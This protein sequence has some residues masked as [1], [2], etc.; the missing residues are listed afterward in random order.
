MKSMIYNDE[1]LFSNGLSTIIMEEIPNNQIV[2]IYNNEYNASDYDLM[3]INISLYKDDMTQLSKKLESKSFNSKVIILSDTN[4]YSLIEYCKSLNVDGFILK[5]Y[6]EKQIRNILQLILT[7][8]KYFP[9]ISI[10]VHLTQK[11]TEIIKMIKERL[12]NKQI[13]YDLGISESTV[14]VHVGHIFKKMSCF[15]RVQL[16][17]KSNAL[18]I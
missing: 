17:N 5:T 6:T 10:D 18:G 14:K 2:K 12:S 8:T 16:I 13:A 11:E 7:G 4:E 9:T 1:E 15:N 3:F